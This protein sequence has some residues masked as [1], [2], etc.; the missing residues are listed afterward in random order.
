MTGP[1]RDHRDNCDPHG[2]EGQEYGQGAPGETIHCPKLRRKR[3]PEWLDDDAFRLG[4]AARYLP[5]CGWQFRVYADEAYCSQA[6]AARA[7]LSALYSTV[8]GSGA[9]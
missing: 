3:R 9:G 7:T 2:Y 6:C 4:L 1:E 5:A 8:Y